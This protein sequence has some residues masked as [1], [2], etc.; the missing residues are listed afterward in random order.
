MPS[1][2]PR[3]WNEDPAVVAGELFRWSERLVG[4]DGAAIHL[5]TPRGLEARWLTEGRGRPGEVIPTDD[6][7]DP[8]TLAA[9]EG[10]TQVVGSEA[11]RHSRALGGFDWKSAVCIPL[12]IGDRVAG[13]FSAGWN[14]PAPVTDDVRLVLEVA[15]SLT[16][17]VL[18]RS[19]LLE[20]VKREQ[21]RL[22]EVMDWLPVV[23]TIIDHP[24]LTIRWA[25]SKAR[26]L[27]GE[28]RGVGAHDVLV[29]GH[30]QVF[31]DGTVPTADGVRAALHG[32][33]PLGRVKVLT[34][35]GQWRVMETTVAPL[36]DDTSLVIQ[37]DVTRD[38]HM[39][40][41][42]DRFVHMLSHHLR[43]PLTPVL[44][45]IDLIG[46][47]S[48]DASI[49]EEAIG[50]IR[51]SVSRIEHVVSRMEQIASLR[52]VD[53][54]SMTDLLLEDLVRQATDRVEGLPAEN[55]VIAGDRAA[56]AECAGFHVVQALQE[57]L[58]N[59]VTHGAP[60]VRVT[61][62]GGSQP[63]IEVTDAGDG[64]P[65]EWERA[66]FSPF[67]DAGGGYL[68]PSPDSLG[69]GLNLARA[70][71]LATRGDLAYAHGSFTI[72]LRAPAVSHRELGYPG[73]LA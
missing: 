59:S 17:S 47:P 37:M 39:D 61:L 69:L 56:A 65:P 15:A 27:F 73:S 1:G 18:H 66:V 5:N 23:A 64:I 9:R 63:E 30:L 50:T 28:I 71:I 4:T 14:T 35:E 62:K 12:L 70:L 49:R 40:Q 44:G 22:R 32:D 10:Q 38:A 48:A 72:K 3:L 60:P 58:T 13:V 2:P 46:D 7:T 45:F 21:H 67:L 51:A 57:L 53:A 26:R 34:R 19:G 54:A 31:A 33:I 42:R 8:V 25:N 41:E 36:G 43:T 16:A 6:D 55:L 68:A 52:P 11:R 20:D 29:S 24:T